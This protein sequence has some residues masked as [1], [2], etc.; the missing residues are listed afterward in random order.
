EPAAAAGAHRGGEEDQ[1]GA[2]PVGASAATGPHGAGRAP[3]DPGGSVEAR[4]RQGGR[5]AG[6]ASDQLAQQRTRGSARLRTGVMEFPGPT[7]E[8]VSPGRDRKSVV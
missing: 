1:A 2:S 6:I 3:R 8:A 5:A 4:R 7:M